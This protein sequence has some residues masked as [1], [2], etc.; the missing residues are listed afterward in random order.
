MKS[1]WLK[2]TAGAL[3]AF[4]LAC[5][6][7]EPGAAS[8]KHAT[9]SIKPRLALVGG[10]WFDGTRFVRDD[11]YA[12][13]GRLTRTRPA[14]IDATVDM[15]GRFVLPPM[16]DAH[17]HNLQN[18]WA[19]APMADDYLRRGVFYSAQ[20]AAHTESIAGYRDMFGTPGTPDVLWAEATLSATDGHPIALAIG[21]SKGSG[22]ELTK[23]DL[24]DKAFWAVDTAAD[25]DAKWAAIEQA[26]PKLVKVIVVDAANAAE[27]RKDPKRFGT[28]GLDPA[29]VPAVV[30]RAHAIG[31]RVAAHVDTA[32]DIDRVTRAGVDIVAH[33]ITR[34]PKGRAIEDL[35]VSDATIAEM[36]RRGTLVIP[37]VAVTRYY[38]ARNPDR[39]EALQGVIADNLARMKRAG[40]TLLTGSDLWDGSVVDEVRALV[41]TGVFTPSEALAMAT[42]TTP[43]ALFP[44]RMIG[45]FREGAEASLIA[46]DRDPTA[47]LD[48]L[49]SVAVAIKQGELLSR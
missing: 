40:V 16:A 21:L 47:D 49:G 34:I 43:R 19:A 10:Q 8:E 23:E 26:R 29:L 39:S 45:A 32:D 11:W 24:I 1:F 28:H 20:L 5:V 2:L 46:F 15:A 42:D 22:N 41:G 12:V 4:P 14:R 38:L 48:A 17:N 44:Q 18:R 33:L 36:K 9:R 3:L 27:N 13:D 30:Q 7:S 35:R 6:A 37:T 25:L 31:A